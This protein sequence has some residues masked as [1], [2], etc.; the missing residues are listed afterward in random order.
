M[1][2]NEARDVLEKV[3][4]IFGEAKVDYGDIRFDRSQSTNISKNTTEEKVSYRATEGFHLRVLKGGE[5]RGMSLAGVDKADIIKG[6]RNLSKY[7]PT[8]RTKAT[9]EPLDSWTLDK[10]LK[11]KKPFSDVGLEEKIECVRDAFKRLMTGRKIVN[12]AARYGEAVGQKFFMNTEGSKLFVK[13]PVVLL[14][15]ASYA[16]TGKNVQVDW[17]VKSR[18]GVGYD[19]VE[20]VDINEICKETSK[21]ALALLDAEEAPAGKYPAVLDPDMAGLIAHESF[22]HGLEAD[23]VLRNRSFLSDKL[24]KQVASENT[25]IV[26]NSAYKEAYGTYAFDDEGVKSKSNVLVENGIL[27]GFLHSRETAST[28][29]AT[30]TGNGRAEDFSHKIY[31]RMSNTYFERGDWSLEEMLEGISHGVYLIKSSHG[32]EDP[33]GGG[34]QVT[35]AKG[36]LIENGELTKLLRPISLSGNVLELLN[37]VDAVGK[38]FKLHSGSCGKG[39]EDWVRVSSGG[40]SIR[41]KEAIVGGG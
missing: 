35:S 39:Y 16:K 20:S 9:Y 19:Y 1:F 6:S 18:Y 10:A 31:V 30:P 26:D 8:T 3:I 12:S 32:M 28:L 40:P 37:N 23:Q 21:G 7:T 41:V 29:G 5:W 27:K 24:N 2:E 38:D 17:N 34:M 22:G 11:A 4:A 13:V 25:T 36:Y 33:L 15:F 14:A